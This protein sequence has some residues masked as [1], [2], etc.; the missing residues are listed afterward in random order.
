MS[1]TLNAQVFADYFRQ[2]DPYLAEIPGRAH[3]VQAF[4]LEDALALT[5][6]RVDARDEC[7]VGSFRSKQASR[8]SQPKS[9]S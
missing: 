6:L 5:G 4:Y 9:A 2:F 7:A 3:P 8:G 1:A